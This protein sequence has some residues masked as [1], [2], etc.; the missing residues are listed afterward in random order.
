MNDD[1]DDDHPNS[2][3]DSESWSWIAE[4]SST[5]IKE[6]LSEFAT[7]YIQYQDLDADKDLSYLTRKQKKAAKTIRDLFLEAGKEIDKRF[8]YRTELKGTKWQKAM[9]EK[10]PNTAKVFAIFDY[11]K[12]NVK[13]R[14]DCSDFSK[15]RG[16]NFYTHT[17]KYGE[18][19]VCPYV[20]F[21]PEYAHMGSE[22]NLSKRQIQ[23]YLKVLCKEYPELIKKTGRDGERG[24][25]IY[26]VGRWRP[27]YV[28]IED[29]DGSIAREAKKEIKLHR[30]L[31][32]KRPIKLADDYRPSEQKMTRGWFLKQKTAKKLKDFKLT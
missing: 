1:F 28:K 21:V 17:S 9:I 16:I 30:K 8:L 20:I 10:N 24:N 6:F 26:I 12:E 13:S 4:Y 18:K 25:L 11:I 31:L 5:Q 32:G 14:D 2:D 23:K 27:Y 22:L 19:T 29:P 15:E 3:E 7:E